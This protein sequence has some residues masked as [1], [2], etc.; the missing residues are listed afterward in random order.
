MIERGGAVVIRM[1]AN[2]QQLTIEP[3]IKA[4]IARDTQVYT[5]EYAIYNPLSEWGYRHKMVCHGAGEYARDDDVMAS[6]K[7]MSTRWK[8]FGGSYVPGCVRIEV[9][10]NKSC[11]C[12]WA[13]LSLFTMPKSEAKP[14]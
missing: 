7:C 12:T 9:S 14:C 5:D 4:T 1:L 3:L 8:A 11:R 10:L 13:F 6:V 2:V